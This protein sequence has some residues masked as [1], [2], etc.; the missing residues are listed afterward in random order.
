MPEEAIEGIKQ[1]LPSEFGEEKKAQ[2]SS[3][4]ASKAGSSATTGEQ[5]EA[6]DQESKYKK[7]REKMNS[8]DAL[9]RAREALMEQVSQQLDKPFDVSLNG[10]ETWEIEAMLK[11]KWEYD[12]VLILRLC[13]QVFS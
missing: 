11:A 9:L 2:V 13:S 5:F 8:L 10:V 6:A 7:K 3:K 12:Q 1:A 4:E